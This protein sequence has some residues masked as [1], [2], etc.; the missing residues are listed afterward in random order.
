[1]S[2][3]SNG[4]VVLTRSRC[5]YGTLSKPPCEK[6]PL[7]DNC[8]IGAGLMESKALRRQKRLEK[9]YQRQWRL[10]QNLAVVANVKF[11][12]NGE[13]PRIPNA[14]SL[15]Y[16]YQHIN[17]A[18]PKGSRRPKSKRKHYATGH[19]FHDLGQTSMR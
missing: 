17:W 6:C 12:H 9:P 15:L 5:A 8:Q 11:G 4:K 3:D 16:G 2:K 14:K 1:M 10:E 7:L 19:R 13:G 18:P